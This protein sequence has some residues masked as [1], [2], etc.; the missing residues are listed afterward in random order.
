MRHYLA[1]GWEVEYGFAL[2]VGELRI[3]D[4]ISGHDNLR[5]IF[6]VGDDSRCDP[7]P[8]SWILRVMQKK[9]SFAS[10]EV[11]V[12]KARIKLFRSDSRL[13]HRC[14]GWTGC[15][16]IRPAGVAPVP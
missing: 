1:Q 10:N 16:S 12:L 8:M 7:M 2:N 14:A 13:A 11:A 15:D 9:N 4:D 3:H 6:Y 5:A